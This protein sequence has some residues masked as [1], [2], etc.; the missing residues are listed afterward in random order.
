MKFILFLASLA[1]AGCANLCDP[2][3]QN[4]IN[5]AND[6]DAVIEGAVI[7]GAAITAPP[8]DQTVTTRRCTK[9]ARGNETCV[10][11]TEGN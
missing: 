9:D 7:V 8:D 3:D 5:N 4:C 11:K 2:K 6:A 10:T 1:L